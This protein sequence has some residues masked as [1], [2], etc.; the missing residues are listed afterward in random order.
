MPPDLTSNVENNITIV[1]A[2]EMNSGL[3]LI[4]L[5]D[6][7]SVIFLCFAFDTQSSN[8]VSLDREANYKKTFFVTLRL[9][10]LTFHHF[11]FLIKYKLYNDLHKHFCTCKSFKNFFVSNQRVI[12]F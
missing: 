5:R 6:F 3:N 9:T 1:K 10:G 7:F 8:F 4:K 2:L 11:D 12:Y